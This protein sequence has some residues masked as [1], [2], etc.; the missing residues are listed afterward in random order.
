MCARNSSLRLLRA[1]AVWLGLPDEQAVHLHTPCSN[2][3]MV[4]SPTPTVCIPCDNVSRLYVWPWPLWLPG[5]H[6][7]I[8]LLRRSSASCQGSTDVWEGL[9]RQVSLT[10]ALTVLSVKDICAD[11]RLNCCNSRGPSTAVLLKSRCYL[12]KSGGDGGGVGNHTGKGPSI[13]A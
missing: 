13:T 2:V 8:L 9:R 12:L 4:T 10:L 7:A 5:N 3:A 1:C 11:A 6:S